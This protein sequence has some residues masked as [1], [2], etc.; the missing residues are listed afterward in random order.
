MN[1]EIVTPDGV[2][3]KG[4]IQQGKDGWTAFLPALGGKQVSQRNLPDL[5]TALKELGYVRLFGGKKTT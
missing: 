1:I 4:E 5:L 3:I 2:V